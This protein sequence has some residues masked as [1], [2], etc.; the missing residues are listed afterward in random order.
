[1]A[2]NEETVDVAPPL[3]LT[4]FMPSGWS[5]LPMGDPGADPKLSLSPSAWAKMAGI[6]IL[7]DSGWMTS[8][9]L[10]HSSS[11][12]TMVIVYY[13]KDAMQAK[14]TW[15]E[16]CYLQTEESPILSKS[17]K[18]NIHNVLAK[19]MSMTLLGTRALRPKLVLLL[20][21]HVPKDCWSR[22][23]VSRRSRFHVDLFSLRWCSPLLIF[24]LAKEVRI[25]V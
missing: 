18:S 25:V 17:L 5:P 16:E 4:A 21:Y 11:M 24:V 3:Q 6:S 10:F 2:Q 13:F 14:L 9:I 23:C 22:F 8:L 19:M 1:M 12:E 20:Y 7:S 15:H